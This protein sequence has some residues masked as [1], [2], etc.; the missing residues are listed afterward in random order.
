MRYNIP[1]FDP[2][3]LQN[4]FPILHRSVNGTRLVYLDNAATSQKPTVVIDAIANYYRTSNANVHRGVHTLSDESTHL[5]ENS[6]QDIAH[7]FGAEND[8]LILT[9]NTTEALNGVAYGWGDG[10]IH[11]GDVI[12][13][14]LIEH[15]ANIVPWQQL[16]ART[17]ARL[18]FIN[19]DVDGRVD[20]SHFEFLLAG[21]GSKVKLI[22]L[23]HVSNAVGTLLP[24]S[25]IVK[26]IDTQ[27][28][29]ENRPKICIDGAQSAPHIPI[30]FD[31][32]GVDFFAFSGHKMLGP[33]GVG[34]LLVKKALLKNNEM[35]P[36]QFGGG[37]IAEVQRETTTFNDTISERFTPGTPDV[38][39]AVGL[40]AACRYL[41]VLGMNAV[42]AHDQ[43]L[44]AYA[45]LKLREEKMVTLVGPQHAIGTAPIDRVGSVSFIYTGVHA[46]DVAQVLDSAGIAVRS[47]HHCTMPLHTHFHWQATVRVSFSVYTTTE[48]IDALIEGLHKVATVFHS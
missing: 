43:Q 22:A 3:E 44:V 32:M 13:T 11:A 5:W 46:H 48:D 6:R 34:G 45:I 20:L 16:A 30:S 23:A 33:M 18:D 41:A 31:A 25:E 36:W 10:H 15:H 38:A 2:R 12:L 14:T 26:R 40:A 37:M 39:S 28:T 4:D 8:E 47:G 35:K 27:F 7:F 42:Q 1:M 29:A 17:G 24:L 19:L 9:R 21:Y